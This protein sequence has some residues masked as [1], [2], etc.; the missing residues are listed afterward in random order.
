MI[1]I[2]IIN[3][4]MMIIRIIIIT[5]RVQKIVYIHTYQIFHERF[6]VFANFQTKFVSFCKKSLERER[7]RYLTNSPHKFAL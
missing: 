3:L 2:T 4:L 7:K 6:F 5:E 1:I